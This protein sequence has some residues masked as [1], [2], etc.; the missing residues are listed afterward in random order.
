MK[1]WRKIASRLSEFSCDETGATAVEFAM[2]ATAFIIMMFGT[3][4]T[5]LMLYHKSSLKWAV[6][7]AARSAIT[8]ASVSQSSLQ[9]IVNGHL[10]SIGVPAATVTYTPGV[11]NGVSAGTVSASFTHSY[12]I[13]MVNTF[14]LTFSETVVVPLGS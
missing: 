3:I 9:A 2:V 8:N 5:G 6:E 11:S 14:T 1:R 7:L 4:Y 10:T 13:P 12:T